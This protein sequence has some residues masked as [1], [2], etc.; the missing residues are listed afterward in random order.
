MENGLLTDHYPIEC[1]K[2]SVNKSMPERVN[3]LDGEPAVLFVQHLGAKLYVLT[4]LS[5]FVQ[6]HLTIVYKVS[7]H[8]DYLSNT[9]ESLQMDGQVFTRAILPV[10]YSPYYEF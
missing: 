4:Y 10:P 7:L 8:F 6:R 9:S 5:M 3:M 1:Q 2:W